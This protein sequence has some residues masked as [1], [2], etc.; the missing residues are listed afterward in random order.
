MIFLMRLLCIIGMGFISVQVS[1]SRVAP[2]LDLS[3]HYYNRVLT[4]E[5]VTRQLAY[6]ETMIRRAGH[7][8][9]VRRL[10]AVET[11][12]PQQGHAHKEVNY[13]VLPRHVR[14]LAKGQVKLEFIDAAQRAVISVA[15]AEYDN[16]GFDGSWNN[17]FFLLNPALIQQLP[18]SHRESPNA[19]SVWHEGQKNGRFQRILWDDKNQIPLKIETGDIAGVTYQS[20]EVK[21]QPRTTKALPWKNIKG[22]AQ[23]E[24]SDYLD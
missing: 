3:L 11:S 23:K 7:V 14:L 8:W 18:R 12:V 5:G 10:P 21:I 24:Y 6:E 4:P 22:Y 19:Q 9:T 20:L 2:D 15:V 16:V 13:T 17:S 1:A